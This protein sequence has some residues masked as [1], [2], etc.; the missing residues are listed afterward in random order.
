M[1]RGMRVQRLGDMSPF[2][3]SV[4]ALTFFVT[5]LIAFLG[6]GVS[7]GSAQA[8]TPIIHVLSNRADLISGGDALVAIDL[9]ENGDPSDVAVYLNGQSIDGAFAVRANGR[10]EGLVTG[11]QDGDNVLSASLP[12]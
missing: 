5:G 11:L 9:P 10:Y 4:L 12:N 3:G 8:P 6:L 7:V 1:D 2:K